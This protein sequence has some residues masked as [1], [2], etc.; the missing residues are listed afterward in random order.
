MVLV[1]Y[2]TSFVMLLLNI[3]DI[4]LMIIHV[5]FSE[6]NYIHNVVK[7]PPSSSKVSKT[8]TLKQ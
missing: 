8:E 2:I 4:V 3:Y 6:I 5:Q 7:S 1:Y